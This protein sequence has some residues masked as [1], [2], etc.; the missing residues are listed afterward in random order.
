MRFAFFILIA[1]LLAGGPT[2]AADT[3]P[4]QDYKPTRVDGSPLYPVHYVAPVAG[5]KINGLVIMI[6]DNAGWDDESSALARHLADNGEV[7]VGLELPIYRAALQK[8]DQQC[9]LVLRDLEILA[10]DVEKDLPFTEYRPPVILGVGAGSGIAYSAVG[11]ELPNT[12]A[13]GIGLRFD[14]IIDVGHKL[15]LPLAPTPPGAPLRY[16]PVTDHETPFLFTPSAAFAAPDDGMQDFVAAMKEAH[17]IQ[18]AHSGDLKA[19]DAAAVDEALRQ[20]PR[21]GAGEESVDGLPLVEIPPP[22]NA[23]PDHHPVVIFYSG[24]GGWRDIDKQIGGYFA[25]QGYFVVGVDSLRYFW[26]KK[27]PREMASDLDRLIR[28]YRPK[29]KGAGVILVGYSFG[30]DLTPFMVNRLSPDTKAEVKLITL[31]G[32]ADRASFEIRLQGILG[33]HNTDGPQTMPELEKIKNIPIL[34]VYGEAEQ[35]S[36]CARK[37]LDGI[38]S[39]VELNGGHHF[40][41]DYQ[42]TADLIIAADKARA[43]KVK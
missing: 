9:T 27:E 43:D 21:V 3:K 7:V 12:F 28:H 6:S 23:A 4:P 11:T 40:D 32:I 24:D 20:I 31:L 37:E 16:A 19:D 42:H 13:G 35:D 29:S 1:G 26:R 22:A 10:R 25:N 5:K 8:E 34:C 33:A 41:G 15:C 36:V 38:V 30:A 14:P 39:R 2:Y 18:S 17:V